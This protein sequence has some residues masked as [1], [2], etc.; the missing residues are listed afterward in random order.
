MDPQMSRRTTPSEGERL[1]ISPTASEET[2]MSALAA[3]LDRRAVDP[4]LLDM[5]E[6][7]LITDYFLICH[8]TSDV[9]IRGLADSVTEALKEEKRRPI[10]VEGGRE[11]G[12]ILLDYGDFIVHIFSED[13]RRFYDL[14]R[15]WSDAHTL[16]I[17][18]E[19]ES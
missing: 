3:L 11:G 7:T 9:H 8:G 6:V 15:L 17:P 1:P 14:E 2:V 18:A 19:D 13:Q 16:P 10:A 12:W 5:R 4:V